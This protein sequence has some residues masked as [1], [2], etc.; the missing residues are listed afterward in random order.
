MI[1]NNN[2][3]KYFITKPKLQQIKIYQI[4]NIILLINKQYYSKFY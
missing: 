1:N 4:K 2:N 3:L